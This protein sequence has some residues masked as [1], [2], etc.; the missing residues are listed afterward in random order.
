MEA[1]APY[2]SVSVYGGG[3]S[4]APS[5]CNRSRPEYTLPLAGTFWQAEKVNRSLDIDVD[6]F[7]TASCRVKF[8]S[9]PVSSNHE[10]PTT[11]DFCLRKNTSRKTV[12]NRRT[13]TESV[14]SFLTL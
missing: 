8:V 2:S 5:R 12:D 1:T 10:Q 3:V 14:L 9:K 13:P 4:A 6:R 11:E 7:K